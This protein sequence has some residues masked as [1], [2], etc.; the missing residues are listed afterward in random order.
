[1]VQDAIILFSARI[2]KTQ[3]DD[4]QYIYFYKFYPMLFLHVSTGA[5]GFFYGRLI[6]F[7]PFII[8]DSNYG[9]DSDSSLLIQRGIK[10]R[11]M[12]FTA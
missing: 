3:Y 10:L 12:N 4:R 7:V 2:T 8:R 6:H 5:T 1:M 11:G 9:K